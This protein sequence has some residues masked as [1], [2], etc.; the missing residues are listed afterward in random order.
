MECFEHNGESWALWRVGQFAGIWS[1]VDGSVSEVLGQ[2]ELSTWKLPPSVFCCE[3]LVSDSQLP[4]VWTE[5]TL[6]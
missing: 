3:Q 4:S 6:W 2:I 1:H 5:G